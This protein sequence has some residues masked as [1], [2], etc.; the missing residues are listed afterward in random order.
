MDQGASGSVASLAVRACE[1]LRGRQPGSHDAHCV[2]RCP[3][4]LP[5]RSR[6]SLGSSTHSY[7]L[8]LAKRL[9]TWGPSALQAWMAEDDTPFLLVTTSAPSRSPTRVPAS[10]ATAESEPAVS[11]AR[12]NSTTTPAATSARCVGNIRVSTTK[13]PKRSTKAMASLLHS[14]MPTPALT[15]ARNR[16]HMRSNYVGPKHQ[17]SEYWGVSAAWLR[18]FNG[19]ASSRGSNTSA[20]RWR[21]EMVTST[22]RSVSTA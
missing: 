1:H 15:A 17:K 8:C 9:T 13:L 11:H 19:N 22:P 18:T 10:S 14:A 12:R 5:V 21:R 4:Q 16:P 2:A 7:G 3:G 20:I 6:A